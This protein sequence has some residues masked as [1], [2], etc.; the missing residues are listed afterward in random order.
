M[1]KLI[2]FD[3]DGLLIDSQSL[4]HEAY[5][6]VFS[7]YDQPISKK[8]WVDF[9]I[10][11]SGGPKKWIE[12]RKLNLD[13]QKIRDEKKVI[14][15]ELIQTKMKLKSG[16]RGLVNLLYKEFPLIVA[17]GSRIESIEL[18]LKKFNLANK[19][20]HLISD[21]EMEKRKP[22]PDVFLYS[23][24][25]MNVEPEDC[26]VFEDSIAG[27]Q[28]AKS[29]GMKCVVCP[30]NFSNLNIEQYKDADKIVDQLSDVNL[31]MIKSI[32]EN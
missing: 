2:I 12:L 1:F 4:Q 27:L 31:D 14:Y 20:K 3:L 32:G 9:W 7:Q 10:H 8:D 22:H 11:K 16:A 6:R 18:C 13:H 17:S 15:D 26:L 21:V 24:K 25:M 28:S 30:D 5:S 23:A 19:F 29:A